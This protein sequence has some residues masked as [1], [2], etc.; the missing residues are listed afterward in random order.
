M[1]SYLGWL[2]IFSDEVILSRDLNVRNMQISSL[3]KKHPRQDG[4]ATTTAL[5]RESARHAY[6]QCRARR[7]KAIDE[8][9]VE[10]GAGLC[11]S[12]AD[13]GE[14][15]RKGVEFRKTDKLSLTC[16]N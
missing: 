13:E 7:R 10:C 5:M 12:L 4:T 16:C 1:Q 9:R 3:G 6:K 15:M 14:Q 11:R 8:T 2:E